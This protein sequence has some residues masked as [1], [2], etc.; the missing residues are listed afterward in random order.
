MGPNTAVRLLELVVALGLPWCHRQRHHLLR[1]GGKVAK[2]VTL[3]APHDEGTEG[4]AEAESEAVRTTLF[5]VELPLP[6]RPAPAP[7]LAPLR[8]CPALVR[9]ALLLGRLC[10][11][12]LLEERDE[13]VGVVGLEEEGGDEGEDV[14]EFP[15]VVL[16]GRSC[17]GENKEEGKAERKME[18][19]MER[20]EEQGREDGEKDG[21]RRREVKVLVDTDTY[22]RNSRIAQLYSRSCDTHHRE[23]TL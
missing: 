8:A 22:R 4:A 1:L 19:K 20:E 7:A 13:A 16:D 23:H 9:A 2:D 6:L 17:K 14:D 5:D 10:L 12:R 18:R 3:A 21:E 15:E 11:A